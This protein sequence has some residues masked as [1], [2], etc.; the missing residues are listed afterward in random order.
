MPLF[1]KKIFSTVKPLTDVEASETIYTIPHTKEQFKS[2]EY[3]LK[4]ITCEKN[5]TWPRSWHPWCY[6]LYIGSIKIAFD[7]ISSVTFMLSIYSLLF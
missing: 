1:G 5:S 4:T 7:M 6:F 3:P 2:E